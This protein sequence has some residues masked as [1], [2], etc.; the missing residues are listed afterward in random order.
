MLRKA[1]NKTNDRSFD[2]A[3]QT[4]INA[5]ETLNGDHNKRFVKGAL[6]S[7]LNSILLF[8]WRILLV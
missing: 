3:E 8:L 7:A 2:V 1:L 5:L 4:A 6:R